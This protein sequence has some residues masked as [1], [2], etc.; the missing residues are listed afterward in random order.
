MRNYFSEWS[1]Y[2]RR[3]FDRL[4][5]GVPRKCLQKE[6]GERVLS[7]VRRVRLARLK[8]PLKR[9]CRNALASIHIYAKTDFRSTPA[10]RH[11]TVSFRSG[12]FQSETPT[13]TIIIVVS[14]STSLVE[15]LSRDGIT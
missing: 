1:V 13:I 10:C 12:R 14:S 7:R 5:S 15:R 2:A 9:V 8:K 3:F 4:H 11:F 6:N